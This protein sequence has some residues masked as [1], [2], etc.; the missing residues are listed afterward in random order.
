MA[1]THKVSF[2][3]NGKSVDVEV[4]AREPRRGFPLWD[5]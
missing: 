2:K 4:E 5:N 3:L 1:N